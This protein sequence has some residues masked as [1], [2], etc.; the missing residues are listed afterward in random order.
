MDTTL[1]QIERTTK[2]IRDSLGDF[3]LNHSAIMPINTEDILY[4]SPEGTRYYY[5]LTKEGM[6]LQASLSESY[7]QYYSLLLSAVKDPP[8]DVSSKLTKSKQVITRAIE[9]KLTWCENT[10]QVLGQC[11]KALDEQVALVKCACEK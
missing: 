11:L 8:E 6:R 4:F 9:H 10:T 7:A 1:S 2:E 5:D 3:L